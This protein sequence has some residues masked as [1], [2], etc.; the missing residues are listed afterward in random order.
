LGDRFDGLYR[1]AQGRAFVLLNTDNVLSR[2]RF[3]MKKPKVATR[4]EVPARTWHLLD[5]LIRAEAEA[6]A[7]REAEKKQDRAA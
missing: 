4:S 3:T 2:Q 5:V 1:V 6:A 7:R